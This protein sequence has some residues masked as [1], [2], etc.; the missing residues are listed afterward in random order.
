[1]WRWDSTF[2][3]EKSVKNGRGWWCS[4]IHWH[5]LGICWRP[6]TSRLLHGPFLLFIVEHS[7]TIGNYGGRVYFTSSGTLPHKHSWISPFLCCSLFVVKS[8]SD[9]AEWPLSCDYASTF[10]MMGRPAIWTQTTSPCSWSL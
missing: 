2:W 1:M 8:S 9:A 3:M 10:W 6:P 4:S 7:T 5:K